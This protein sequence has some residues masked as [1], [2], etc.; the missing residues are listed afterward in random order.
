MKKS[1]QQNN[2]FKKQGLAASLLLLVY[3]AIISILY[4]LYVNNIS[5]KNCYTDLSA[6]TRESCKTIE[7]NFRNDRSSLRLLSRVIAQ[8]SNMY[9]NEVNNYMTT[10]DV[11]TL[12]SNIAIL[13]PNDEI[14]QSRLSNSTSTAGGIMSYDKES[15]LGEHISNLRKSTIKENTDVLYSFIPIR[16]SGKTIA[17]LFTELNPASIASAW[18]PEMYDGDTTFCIIDRSTGEILINDWNTEMK[19]IS[20]VGSTELAENIRNGNEGFMQMKSG[21]KDVFVSYMPME[22]ENWEIMFVVGK[23][24]V[25]AYANKMRT[26]MAVFLIAGAVGF[27]AYLVRLMWS[28]RRAIINAENQANIDILTGL[29]NRNLYEKKCK[30]LEGREDGLACIYVDANGLH[31]VNNT[32]GHLAGDQ[33]LRFIADTLK[34]SFGENMVY[35][36]G[37]DEF[38]IFQED[39]TLEFL[40]KILTQTNEDLSKN[41]YHV[42]TG[43]CIGD[44][45]I[46]LNEIIKTAEKRMYD[47]KKRY[48]EKLGKDVRNKIE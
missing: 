36:I 35:R 39:K 25:F 16:I 41:D 44:K 30:A 23:D 26:I 31:E 43:I 27:S 21:K 37:G 46:N 10:Y 4:T 33:M 47:D 28:N 29:Q 38:V 11:N 14:V 19:N 34:V 42:S 6:S 8:E 17:M 1:K 3:I 22:L 12:I 15:A 20:D 40:E 24:K 7:N 32:K 45:K 5:I 18:S 13:M 48:Y 9:S 2:L